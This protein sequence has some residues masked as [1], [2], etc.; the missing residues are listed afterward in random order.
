MSVQPFKPLI[1]DSSAVRW[2][3]DDCR[4]W[5]WRSRCSGWSR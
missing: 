4:T 2:K 5:N 3:R 1:T